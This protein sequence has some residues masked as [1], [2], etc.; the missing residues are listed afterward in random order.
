MCIRDSLCRSCW[1]GSRA[2]LTASRQRNNSVKRG[3][4]RHH[5]RLLATAVAER[6]VGRKLLDDGIERNV[7]QMTS[8]RQVDCSPPSWSRVVLRRRCTIQTRTPARR[9]TMTN[10]IRRHR[11]QSAVGRFRATRHRQRRVVVW[12]P[13]IL[14][15]GR[16]DVV[17]QRRRAEVSILTNGR[18]RRIERGRPMTVQVIAGRIWAH[19]AVT[20]HMQW[21][22]WPFAGLLKR[23][24]LR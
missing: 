22:Q 12:R 6:I 14:M 8:H 21:F 18:R 23:S 4:R 20:T 24:L 19:S 5:R 2:S 15:A 7:S 9:R 3:R 13:I 10:V 11:T 16:A 1:C 17:R